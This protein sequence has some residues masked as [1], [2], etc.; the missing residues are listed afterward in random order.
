MGSQER[1]ARPFK[2]RVRARYNNAVAYHRESKTDSFYTRQQIMAKAYEL[3]DKN[4]KTSVLDALSG[5]GAAQAPYAEKAARMFKLPE[6]EL[7]HKQLKPKE[8]IA[9]M[10]RAELKHMHDNGYKWDDTF[11]QKTLRA[12]HLQRCHAKQ[13]DQLKSLQ[14]FI[15]KHK[16]HGPIPF[17]VSEADLLFPGDKDTIQ[18]FTF[19]PRN[20][21]NKYIPKDNSHQFLMEKF[22]DLT[23]DQMAGAAH[24]VGGAKAQSFAHDDFGDDLPS[25]Y[26]V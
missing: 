14:D 16:T 25:D 15:E 11:S 2:D 13:K 9:R 17:F 18:P 12:F 26:R 20:D 8:I 19:K 4:D 21:D 24:A 5:Q 22:K 6:D 7:T 3:E 1:G 23:P 10:W